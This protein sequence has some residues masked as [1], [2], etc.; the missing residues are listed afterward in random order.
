[1]DAIKEYEE[2]FDQALGKYSG[3][4]VKLELKDQVRPI[5]FKPRNVAMALREPIEKEVARLERQGVLQRVD[6]SDWAT[7]IVAVKKPDGSIRICEDYKSTVN[8]RIRSHSLKVPSVTDLLMRIKKGKIFAKLDMSQAYQQLAVD[9]ETAHIQAITTHKGT[10]RVKRLKFG[11]SAAPG[12]FQTLMMDMLGGLQ[13]VLPYFDDVIVVANDE[14][15]LIEKLRRVLNIFKQN[16][17]RLCKDKC[18]FAANT[19]SFLEYQVTEDGIQPMPAK[20]AAIKKAPHYSLNLPIGVVADASPY[21]VGAVLYHIMS[22]GAEKPN[23][24]IGTKAMPRSYISND[25]GTPYILECI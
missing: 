9:V 8:P 2:V 25:A 13:G 12:L 6:Y 18:V 3:P 4:P 24:N 16:G 1:M 21:G 11:I 7:P 5:A 17:L 19:V 14:K 10:Y 20:V 23:W 15:D 22:D